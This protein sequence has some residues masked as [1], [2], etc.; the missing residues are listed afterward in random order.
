MTTEL[1]V[2][3]I[4]ADRLAELEEERRFL[5]RSLVDLEREHDAGDVDDHDY[6]VL[7]DGYTARAA[8]VLRAID[9]GRAALP[10][11]KPRNW[12]R[13][14]IVTVAVIVVA[15][16]AGLLVAR[17]SGQRSPGDAITGGTSP[18]QVATLLSEGRVLMGRGALADASDR[19]LAVLDIEP[20]NVEAL[21]Y[22]GWLVA[23]ASQDQEPEQAT[24]NLDAGKA[25]MLKAIDVDPTYADPHCLLAVIAANF[26]NDLPTARTRVDE[27]LALD[28]PSDLRGLIDTFAAG[29]DSTTT[30]LA[31][32]TTDGN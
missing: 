3:G 21:T 1:Q 10:P 32:V 13:L 9:E 31:P 30:T 28:P 5:L 11:R 19:F 8:T 4:D 20:N 27:C 12:R 6:A 24:S 25:F 26:E 2:K 7:K 16:V 29:L 23:L 17:S 18:N 15:A 14:A 22:S